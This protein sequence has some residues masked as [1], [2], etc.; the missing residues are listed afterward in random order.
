MLRAIYRTLSWFLLFSSASR[1][2]SSDAQGAWS[3]A[4]ASGGGDRFENPTGLAI[5]CRGLSVGSDSNP[6]LSERSG[7]EAAT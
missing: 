2:P 3:G 4:S 7:P 1:R 5:L 6:P